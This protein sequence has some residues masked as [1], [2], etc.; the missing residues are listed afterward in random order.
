M[1]VCACSRVRVFVCARV[2]VCA[3]SCVPVFVCARVRVCACARVCVTFCPSGCFVCSLVYAILRMAFCACSFV[4]M[5]FASV[6]F[7]YVF[8]V[9]LF[10]DAASEFMPHSCELFSPGKGKIMLSP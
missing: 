10:S 6:C 4:F 1:R 3:C 9:C 7:V 2:R 8:C 5:S